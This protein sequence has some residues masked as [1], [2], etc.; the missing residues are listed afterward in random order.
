MARQTWEN[1]N[2]IGEVLAKLGMIYDN[3]TELYVIL[4]EV[5]AARDGEVSLLAKEQ[6]QDTAILAV[7]GAN[8]S[9]VSS[10]DTTPGFLNGKLI[11]GAGITL[12]E[13]SDGGD[14]TLAISMDL[15]GDTT[16]QL[17]SDLDRNGNEITGLLAE[18][19]AIALYF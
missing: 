16:P 13:G 7:T 6:A 9:L 10:N 3:E 11:E 12:T 8:G 1:S 5:E 18:M 19:H 15:I 14:E 2:T 4:A 17:G